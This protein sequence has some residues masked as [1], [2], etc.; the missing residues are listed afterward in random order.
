MERIFWIGKGDDRKKRGATENKKI[1]LRIESEVKNMSESITKT[2]SCLK[3]IIRGF[4]KNGEVVADG[5]LKGFVIRPSEEQCRICAK[6][7]HLVM[8]NNGFFKPDTKYWLTGLDEFNTGADNKYTKRSRINY[9]MNIRLPKLLGSSTLDEICKGAGDF[10]KYEKIIDGLLKK[11]QS[12][13]VFDKLVFK[14]KQDGI[15]PKPIALSYDDIMTVTDIFTTYNKERIRSVEK[16]LTPELIGHIK[17]ME[18]HP[19]KLSDTDKEIWELINS[20]EM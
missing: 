8:D 12:R 15:K 17:Y 2:S 1:E 13:S 18:A 10:V 14:V 19:D 9:D 6:I 7:A 11:Y 16:K 5:S 4:Y 20:P 3:A